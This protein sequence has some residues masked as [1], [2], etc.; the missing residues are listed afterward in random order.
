MGL[1]VI[2]DQRTGKCWNPHLYEYRD[3]NWCVGCAVGPGSA[4]VLTWHL[5]VLEPVCRGLEH[6]FVRT[7]TCRGLFCESEKRGVTEQTAH[8]GSSRQVYDEKEANLRHTV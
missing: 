5:L 7:L 4:E 3:L 6:N 2:M 1:L 8:V